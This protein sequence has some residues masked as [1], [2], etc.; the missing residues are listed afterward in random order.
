MPDALLPADTRKQSA[1]GTNRPTG[2][3]LILVKHAL[4]TIVPG[5]PPAQWSLADEGRASCA[6]LATHLR[7]YYPAQIAASWQ[8][9][10]RIAAMQA[11]VQRAELAETCALLERAGF[12]PIALKGAWLSAHAYPEPAQRPMRDI[13]LLSSVATNVGGKTLCAFGDAAVTPVL[14]TIKHFRHEYEAHVRE[15]RCT[16]PADWRARQPVGAH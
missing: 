7:R 9:A 16:H 3:H 14:T 12:A 13:D 2:Q 6:T 11:M 10:H 5:T 4:P 1:E 8:A 15:G